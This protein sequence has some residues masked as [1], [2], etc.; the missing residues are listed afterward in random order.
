MIRLQEQILRRDN[1]TYFFGVELPGFYKKEAIQ[2]VPQEQ[3]PPMEEKSDDEEGK[4]QRFFLTEEPNLNEPHLVKKKSSPKN[5][6]EEEQTS[7][8]AVENKAPSKYEEQKSLMN[9]NYDDFKKAAYEI[10]GEG[11]Q[12]ENAINLNSAYKILKNLMKKPNSIDFEDFTEPHYMKPTTVIQ[13]IKFNG[14]FMNFLKSIDF[15][16]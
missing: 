10:V 7:F 6:P 9:Q 8:N 15:Y 4:F 11:K 16:R 13:K 3:V 14:K 5:K 12:Y 2:E 1:K